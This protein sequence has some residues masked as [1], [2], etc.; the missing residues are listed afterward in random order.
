[1]KRLILAALI[2]NMNVLQAA[3]P[4]A[5]APAAPTFTPPDELPL[6]VA[7]QWAEATLAACKANGYTVTVT[8]MNANYDMKLVMRADGANPMTA[9]IGRRKAYTVIKSGVSSGEFG[10][11]FAPPPGTPPA[12]P[13][14]G[15]PIGMPPGADADPNTIIWGGGLPVKIGGRLVGA[16]SVSGAPGADKDI[17]CAEVGLAKIA[18]ALK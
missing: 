15:K 10:A 3:A 16:I 2:L 8:Y 1:M 9:D 18:D 12:A 17:A 7:V 6:A 13:T 4:A 14:P 5:P 11:R